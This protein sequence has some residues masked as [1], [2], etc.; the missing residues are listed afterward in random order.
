MS[1][2]R[3]ITALLD[4]I[5]NGKKLDLTGAPEWFVWDDFKSLILE[6]GEMNFRSNAF[7]DTKEHF[8][9]AL[10]A[11]KKRVNKEQKAQLHK[12]EKK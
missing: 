12:K 6:E 11:L 8:Y 9:N 1:H 7:E 3:T 10:R 4:W 5:D 2:W